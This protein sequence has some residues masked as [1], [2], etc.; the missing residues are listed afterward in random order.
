MKL[1]RDASGSGAV[2]APD[3]PTHGVQDQ[4][5]DEDRRADERLSTGTG[6][7]DGEAA[8]RLGRY[9][10]N[11]L[12]EQERS[13]LLELLSHF[14]APIPWMIEVALLLT[15]I[16]ARWPDFA[17][18]LALLLLNGL[19]GFWEEHQAAN[20]IAALKEQLAKQGRVKLWA[21]AWLEP[22]SR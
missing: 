3:A 13:V 16:T 18:I 15:A 21:Y 8:A 20:A 11:A 6:L 17:I 10:P 14:W 9:G 7:S 12:V 4:R 1:R 19:V 2:A 5:S 22:A